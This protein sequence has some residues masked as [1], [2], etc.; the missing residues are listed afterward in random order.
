L[1]E[2]AMKDISPLV[3]A[4]LLP[5]ALALASAAACAHETRATSSVEIEFVPGDQGTTDVVTTT[6]NVRF[7][8]YRDWSSD[9]PE[10]PFRLATITTEVKLHS[11]REPADP[12][13]K[14]TV[15][16]DAVTSG[17]TQRIGGFSDPGQSGVVIAET[18]FATTVPGCCDAPDFH[19]VRRLETGRALFISSGP[20]E[21]G[22]TAWAEAPNA[23]PRM[24]RWAAFN[25]DTKEGDDKRGFLGTILYGGERGPLSSVEVFAKEPS[26]Y[27]DLW[28]GLAHGAGLLWLDP[29]A[30]G[31][32]R[33]PGAGEPGSPYTIWS[34]DKL[35]DPKKFGGFQLV[36]M[37][38]GKRLAM[39]PVDRDRLAPAQAVVS[40]RLSLAA[41]R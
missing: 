11:Q 25:G 40:P 22:S 17:G 31:E 10:A 9:A 3:M 32:A 27:N 4:A 2:A 26:Q 20:G 15:T 7:Q 6:R 41:G 34:L 5:I 23:R 36:L 37:L 18:Y 21:T 12:D 1:P 30:K 13:A 28:Q 29:K 35:N 19:H 39:I 14:V 38:D 24:Q 16:I 8:T 33:Q